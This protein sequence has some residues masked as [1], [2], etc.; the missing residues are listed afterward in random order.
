MQ[1][2]PCYNSSQKGLW[3]LAFLTLYFVDPHNAEI[4][5]NIIDQIMNPITNHFL[6]DHIH[7]ENCRY[8][9]GHHQAT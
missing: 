6:Q 3:H 5:I 9:L 8:G 2:R 1:S 4:S 7:Q